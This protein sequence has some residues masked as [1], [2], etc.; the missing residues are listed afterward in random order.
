MSMASFGQ[1]AIAAPVHETREVLEDHGHD[2][3]SPITRH[4]GSDAY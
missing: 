1:Y 4:G 3:G 2:P